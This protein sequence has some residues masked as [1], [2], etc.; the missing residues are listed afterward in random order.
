MAPSGFHN[1]PPPPEGSAMAA[2]PILGPRRG[3]PAPDLSHKG[4]LTPSLS[5]CS[6][7]GHEAISG[8]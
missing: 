6:R 5:D 7:D 1:N 2:A 4:N 3:P 8:A